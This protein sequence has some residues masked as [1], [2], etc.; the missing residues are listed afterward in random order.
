MTVSGFGLGTVYFPD[1]AK[2]GRFVKVKN[3]FVFLR[4]GSV[5]TGTV[6]VHDGRVL[7]GKKKLRHERF[8]RPIILCRRDRCQPGIKTRPETRRVRE[9]S[10][11]VKWF[12][13]PHYR[14]NRW[15]EC[16]RLLSKRTLY[17]FYHGGVRLCS[18]AFRAYRSMFSRLFVN[19]SVLFFGAL[20]LKKKRVSYASHPSRGFVLGNRT[21]ATV[22]CTFNIAFPG[23]TSV[24]FG[25]SRIV[26][27]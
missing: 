1:T 11:G 7:R 6:V 9:I 24:T 23:K 3:R 13:E 12:Y 2:Y 22:L 5:P 19:V 25:C 27:V 18:S 21:A 14:R 16:F 8:P 15:R 17:C 20:Q 10:K 26:F 4:T